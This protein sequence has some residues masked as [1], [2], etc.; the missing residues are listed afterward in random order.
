MKQSWGL[1]TTIKSEAADI[2]RFAAYHLD[3]GAHRLFL[4]LD[5]PCPDAELHL[6]THPKC[7]VRLCDDSHWRRRKGGRP[8]KH[9]VRQVFNATHAY[10]RAEDVDWLGHIDVDEFIFG[11]VA[12]Q[13]GT[14][15]GDTLRIRPMELLAGG[16]GTAFKGFVPPGPDRRSRVARMYPTYGDY[17]KGGFLSHVAGKLMVRTGRD[18][19]I[20]NIHNVYDGD[21]PNPGEAEASSLHLAHCHARD[22]AEWYAHFAYRH[23]RGSYRADLPPA[24]KPESGVM[25]LHDMLSALLDEGGEDALR[26]FFDEVAADT[27]DVRGRLNA[28]GGLR[29]ADLDLEAKLKRHFPDFADQSA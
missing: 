12:S 10:A 8:G 26:A 6:S 19:L 16:D 25:S 21:V 15:A 20:Y 18:G 29:F 22:W 2:L 23:K 27:P 14:A 13:L 7:R 28:E 17:L 3:Q 11:D 1:V 9:Q 5:A 24:H 4:Y